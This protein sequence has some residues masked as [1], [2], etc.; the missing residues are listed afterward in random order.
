MRKIRVLIVDDSTVIRRL[1]T[2][3][4]TSDPAIEIAGVAA[5]GKIAL[6]KIPQVAPDI[7]TLDMEMPEMDGLTTLVEI[8]KL[9]PKLPVI[10]FSTLTQSGAEATMEALSKG[11]NDFATKPSN[12]GSVTAAI[13]TVVN[14]LVPKIKQFCNWNSKSSPIARSE[15]WGQSNRPATQ[16]KPLVSVKPSRIEIVV[17][18]VSTGGP[19]ALTAML[20][21]LPENF[22][23]PILIV[24]HMPPVF[25]KHLADRLNQL[26]K[27]HVHEAVDGELLVAGGVWLAPGNFHMTLRRQGPQLKVVLNQEQPEN[28]CRPAVDVLFRSASGL[29]GAN[30]L[31]VVLTGMGQDGQRGCDAIRQA[32]GRV[33][34]QDE[35]TSV[36]WGMP[37]T[38]ANAGLAH[39]I[40]PL[41]KMADEI[42]L[43]TQSSRA[44]STPISVRV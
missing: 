29:F 40:L 38:V 4:L 11:A 27:L 5:N 24:Q 26:C 31:A 23:V 9:Y 42:L 17:I 18:G 16:A 25:T 34:V 33:I 39:K 3:A 32:G 37:G 30:V 44:G 20:P 10:M 21:K 28:S 7:I 13:E 6:A 22:P 19:N 43:Q 14:E 8:R 35:E 2:N 15:V 36:V 1:L 41:P 12:V